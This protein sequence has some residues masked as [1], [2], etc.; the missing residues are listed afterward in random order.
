M[1]ENIDVNFSRL[2]NNGICGI[3]H[4]IFDGIWRASWNT[5]WRLWVCVYVSRIAKKNTKQHCPS[6][7]WCSLRRAYHFS[8]VC[9]TMVF[10]VKL[11]LRGKIAH[12]TGNRTQAKN[13][14]VN[15]I[16]FGNF[17]WRTRTDIRCVHAVAKRIFG[18]K[19]TPT[20]F[21]IA[22]QWRC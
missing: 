4:T 15:I 8:M 21:L 11:G 10:L 20:F 17:V 5:M 18:E 7:V 1:K 6:Q 3:C 16:D 9:V 2:C 12:F 14:A 22:T 19:N 13:T